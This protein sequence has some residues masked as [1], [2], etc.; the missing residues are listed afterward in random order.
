MQHLCSLS[1]SRQWMVSRTKSTKE[2][3]KLMRNKTIPCN[4]WEEARTVYSSQ[5]IIMQNDEKKSRGNGIKNEK[6][7][8][9]N[10]KPIRISRK[11]IEN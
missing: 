4:E 8:K 11:L 6:I 10:R 3:N 9:I 7:V 2:R 5:L 1:L